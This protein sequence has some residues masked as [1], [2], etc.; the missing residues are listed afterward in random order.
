MYGCYWIGKIGDLKDHY[1]DCRH[2]IPSYNRRNGSRKK[3]DTIENKD[4]VT[5]C[6][7]FPYG[8]TSGE[9]SE[10]SLRKHLANNAKYHLNICTEFI[11]KT[12]DNTEI[13]SHQKY[14]A[15][16]IDNI[17]NLLESVNKVIATFEQNKSNNIEI[18]KSL[19]VE[20]MTPFRELFEHVRQPDKFMPRVEIFVQSVNEYIKKFDKKAFLELS[21]PCIADDIY[22][23][24]DYQCRKIS[25][26]DVFRFDQ[27]RLH[28]NYEKLA[29]KLNSLKKVHYICFVLAK[30]VVKK[31]EKR[32]SHEFDLLFTKEKVEEFHEDEVSN[33]ADPQRARDEC[34][35]ENEKDGV[36]YMQ[37]C[38]DKKIDSIVKIM[39]DALESISKKYHVALKDFIKDKNKG[40]NYS[41]YHIWKVET[42]KIGIPE[43]SVSYYKS[44]V[45]KGDSGDVFTAWTAAD[46]PGSEDEE[47]LNNER[48]VIV[49][50]LVRIPKNEI[51]ARVFCFNQNEL[52]RVA[53]SQIAVSKVLEE[54]VT[55]TYAIT[56]EFSYDI[57]EKRNCVSDL[58]YFNT[59]I[60]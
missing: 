51:T 21:H 19:F 4:K 22:S 18:I 29:K 48:M 43:K 37:Q 50:Y 8:C 52:D 57:L 45:D 30:D 5:M 46:E 38:F 10:K 11:N 49:K 1:E 58:I 16:T 26:S 13:E 40:H 20:P 7:Y 33:T 15:D 34:E 24:N 6:P 27:E 53:P 9:L 42:D 44:G 55:T 54:V 35:E 41:D 32:G 39:D 36:G 59:V 25:V 12:H 2:L 60:T 31:V 3:D 17:F 28:D 23:A 56:A 47:P 14:M